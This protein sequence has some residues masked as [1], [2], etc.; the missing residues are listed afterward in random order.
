VIRPG[1]RRLA[2][3]EHGRVTAFVVVLTS[4]CLFFAGLV[5][6]GGLALAAKTR[7]IGQA[8]EAARAG[9]QELDLAAYRAAGVLR[10]D[11]V[12]AQAAARH[13]LATVAA[14]GTVTLTGNTVQVTVTTTQP[15]QLLGLLGIGEITVTGHGQAEPDQGD[16]VNPV[17][18][19]NRVGP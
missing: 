11:P 6:D 15:T 10:L 16:T 2:H 4:G 13:Y 9:A 7:A 3:E 8:Q 18:P 5:L 14:T 1:L 19:R 17:L 12:P